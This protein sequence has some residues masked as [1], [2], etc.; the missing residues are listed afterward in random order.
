MSLPLVVAITGASGAVYAVRLLEVLREAGVDVHLVISP[1]GAA[2]IKQELGVDI[3]LVRF[4]PDSL[5]PSAADSA[6]DP[7]IAAVRHLAGVSTGDSSVLPVATKAPG[8]II[9]HYHTNFMSPIASGSFLTRGMVVCPCSGS[10]MSGIAHGSST[11]L[12]QR[13][14]DVHLKEHR[15]LV[16]V[17]R[18]TPLSTIQLENM[19]I[20]A[21]AGAVVLPAMPGWYHGVKSLQD[22]IDF[23]VARILDQLEVPHTLMRRWG[24]SAST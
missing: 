21:Q 13:A 2:V 15:R 7:K 3:D 4:R 23:I 10:T 17:P 12:V 19:R 6:A 9:Y 1:S 14:A 16:L 18:E 5:L 20:A 11:N 22:L 24:D 8:E